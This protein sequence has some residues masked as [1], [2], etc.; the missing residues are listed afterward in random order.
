MV[1]LDEKGLN[2]LVPFNKMTEEQ[3]KKVASNGGK[4]SA[5]IRSIRAKM[6]KLISY[7]VA[8]EEIKGLLQLFGI[9]E[10]DFGTALAFMQLYKAVRTG[11][12]QAYKAVMETLGE[13]VR[14]EELELKK[15]EIK[16]KEQELKQ[17]EEANRSTSSFEDAIIAAYEKRMKDDKQ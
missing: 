16:L 4:K 12:T 11:D 15:K 2:N 6:R 17:A 8:D 13:T 1:I 10:T 9:E 3:R 14:N 7:D 5:R